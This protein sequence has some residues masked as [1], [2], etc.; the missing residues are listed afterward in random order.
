MAILPSGTFGD[1]KFL[2]FPRRS[3]R[4]VCHCYCLS[5][6][7]RRAGQSR[8][9]Y[10]GRRK[11]RKSGAEAA[12]AMRYKRRSTAAARGTTN[13]SEW[14]F[15]H[16]SLGGRGSDGMRSR[17]ATFGDDGKF[18]AFP[19]RSKR[20]VGNCYCNLAA[21]KFV[22]SQPH[23][24]I[25]TGHRSLTVAAWGHENAG[26]TFGMDVRGCLRGV[27]PRSLW[28]PF[29]VRG[30]YPFSRKLSVRIV[31]DGCHLHIAQWFPGN[32]QQRC[33]AY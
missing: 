22:K 17:L 19:R 15:R 4:S 3:E 7:C 28:S 23:A 21:R 26:R 27:I 18:L 2:A 6:Y 5:Y 24:G 25:Y 16:R 30:P 13:A 33:S 11:S 20:S 31:S 9:R 14:K 12:P 29:P 32:L 1:G 10:C 8:A